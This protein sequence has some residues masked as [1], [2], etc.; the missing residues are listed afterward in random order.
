MHNECGSAISL[1]QK[2]LDSLKYILKWV[3]DLQSKVQ[4]TSLSQTYSTVRGFKPVFT[5]STS[6][7]LQALEQMNVDKFTIAANETVVY[8]CVGV[9]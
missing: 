3:Y 2:N 7:Q 5:H 6:V 9:V 1:Y 8:V 4:Q